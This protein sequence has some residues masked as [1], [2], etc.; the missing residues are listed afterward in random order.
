VTSEPGRTVFTMTIPQETRTG[1][2]AIHSTST[3]L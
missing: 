2:S 1:E 3:N